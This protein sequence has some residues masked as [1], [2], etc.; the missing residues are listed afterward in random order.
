M[1]VLYTAQVHAGPLMSSLLQ[2]AV[3]QED[4]ERSLLDLQRKVSSLDRRLQ[5]NLSPE[6]HLQEL[7]QEVKDT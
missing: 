6:Q 3:A 2:A 5:E 4:R 7:L 1:L